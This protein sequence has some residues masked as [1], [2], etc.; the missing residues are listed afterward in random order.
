MKIEWGDLIII[1]KMMYNIK[2]EDQGKKDLRYNNDVVVIL[3]WIDI[4][5]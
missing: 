1:K 4:Y 2:G 5:L 3:E